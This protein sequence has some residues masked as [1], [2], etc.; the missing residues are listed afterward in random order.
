MLATM[1]TMRTVA[2]MRA[3]PRVTTTTRRAIRMRMRVT[4]THA[5]QTTTNEDGPTTTYKPPDAIDLDG[6]KRETQRR[7]DRAV[8]KVG[9]ATTKLRE[10]KEVVDA[11]MAKEDATAEEL[12]AC[13]DVDKVEEELMGLKEELKALNGLEEVLRGC[14]SVN[15]PKF[16]ED[17]YPRAAELEVNDAPPERPARVKKVKGPK[18]SAPRMPY[19]TFVSVDGIDIRVGRTSSDNDRVSC[20]P[21]CRDSRDWWMHAAGCPGSHVVIRYTGEDLPKETMIDAAVLAAANS[22]ANQVGR[23]PVSLVRCRQVSKPKGAKPGLVQLSGDV[24]TVV[25]NVKDEASRLERLMETK[26]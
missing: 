15:S 24:R 3:T 16:I 14:K 1:T 18:N 11:L 26:T 21:E 23:A 19:W 22:K 9:K 2:K 17:A 25:V 6:L 7:M 8:K 12:D 13:P 4:R 5:T 10:A 20:D